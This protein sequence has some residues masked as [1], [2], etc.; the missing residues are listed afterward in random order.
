MGFR[1]EAARDQWQEPVKAAFRLL[2]DTGFG[3]ERSRGWGRSETP[4]FVEGTL[5]GLIIEYKAQGAVPPVKSRRAK[6][7]R[8][9]EPPPAE[10]PEPEPEPPVEE[11]PNEGADRFP[12][13]PPME[14]GRRGSAA[15]SPS[16]PRRRSCLTKPKRM[17]R[18]RTQNRCTTEV[19]TASPKRE[20]R[21]RRTRS[22]SRNHSKP[23][24]LQPKSRAGSRRAGS[25]KRRH[26]EPRPGAVAAR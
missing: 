13:L 12:K 15:S 22:R 16:E 19:V 3:G 10:E 24:L 17:L 1:D 2:A 4:E 5:P 26:R 18:R 14:S 23:G 8:V 6:S 11:P 9:T 25:R 7:R 20:P 21:H